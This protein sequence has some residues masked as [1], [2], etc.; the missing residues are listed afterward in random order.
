MRARPLTWVLLLILP[1]SSGLVPA[2]AQQAIPRLVET[3][4]IGTSSREG[5]DLFAQIQNVTL[6]PQGEVFVLDSAAPRIRVFD[7]RGRCLYQVGRDGEGP[8]ETRLPIA[9]A[10]ADDG[11]FRILDMP[12]NR[13]TSFAAGG[14]F[15]GTRPISGNRMLALNSADFDPLSG[16]LF[17]VHLDFRVS[18]TV[19]SRLNPSEGEMQE[20]LKMEDWPLQPNGSRALFYPIAAGP[21][22]LLAVG[23]GTSTYE[24]RIYSP[25]GHLL[26]TLGRNVERTN[27]TADEIAFEEAAAT[28][29]AALARRESG[30]R[31]APPRPVINP[32]KPFFYG[33]AL[34]FDKTGR[35]WVNTGRGDVSRTVFDLFDPEGVF[36]G[37]VTTPRMIRPFDLRGERLVGAGFT[38][39]GVP[40]VTLYHIQRTR[41]P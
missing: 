9:C 6:G 21:G 30:G 25:D 22:G 35:L 36:L 31:S 4:V 11:S 37:E 14:S 39:E 32:L 34:G 8:G 23:D 12:L 41:T 27:K 10:V 1:T 38:E 13:I 26:R 40:V 17:L 18:G 3:M 33:Y 29:G 5:P 16:I 28:R 15:I 2:G 20:Y 24:I 7:T 19:I